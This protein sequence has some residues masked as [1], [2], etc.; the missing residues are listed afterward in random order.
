MPCSAVW[1]MIPY[2]SSFN[3]D[4]FDLPQNAVLLASGEGCRNQAFRMN[5]RVYGFQFHLEATDATAR[6][7][8]TLPEA[9]AAIDEC[10]VALIEGDLAANYTTSEGECEVR[11]GTLARPCPRTNLIT[12]TNSPT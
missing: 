9:R 4:T 12:E 3:E 7:W 10:P 8:A 11:H 6:S 1:T 5:D 2:T